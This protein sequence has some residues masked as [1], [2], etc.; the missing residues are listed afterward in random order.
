VEHVTQHK[1]VTFLQVH[2]CRVSLA[3]FLGPEAPATTYMNTTLKHITSEVGRRFGGKC[4]RH[5][6][7]SISRGRHRLKA[8]VFRLD[9]CFHVDI[10]IALF[11]TENIAVLFLR[12]VGR[13]SMHYTAIY[14]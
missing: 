9:A 1:A 5:I 14:L 12:N 10:L 2:T 8:N 4:R 3:K 13:L 6:Q 7:G 11:D